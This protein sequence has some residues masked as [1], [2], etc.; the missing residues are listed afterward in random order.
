MPVVLVALLVGGAAIAYEA[1]GTGKRGP[2]RLDASKTSWVQTMFG[3][4]DV[5][6]NG[7][8]NV[9]VLG[10]D[11]RPDSEEGGSRTDTIMLVRVEPGDGDIRLLSVPR[12]LLVEVGPGQEDR[13]NAAYNFGGIEQTIDAFE[14]Y[15]GVDV[16][17]YAIVDFKGFREVIDTMGGVEMDVE[18]EIPPK[19]EIRD[20]LQT[21]NGAQ[22]L[23]YARYRKTSG[24]DLDRIS[25]QQRLVAALR[26]QAFEWNTVK[27]LPEILRVANRHI[28][29]DMGLRQGIALGRILIKRGP[30]ARMTAHQ[31]QGTPATL[32]NGDQVLIPDPV[33]NT[34]ILDEFRY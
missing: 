9:L 27:E 21:L 33:S 31:L 15:S 13:I 19:Y 1:G 32:E 6:E 16:D 7:P 23:F 26:S 28:E 14:G 24:G 12:D 22:A 8:F 25:R 3:G 4:E 30:N 20:G 5:V 11:T 34:P 2:E 18:D 17:H 10:V 29:T